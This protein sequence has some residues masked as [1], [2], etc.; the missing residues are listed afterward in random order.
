MP[1]QP[2]SAGDEDSS[3]Q[4]CLPAATT[5]P[6][7]AL[8]IVRSAPVDAPMIVDLDHTLHLSNSTEDFID[9]ARPRTV[10]VVL[11]KVAA[12]AAPWRR[13]ADPF[14]SRE[15][16][17]VGLITWLMPW[18]LLRW[19]HHLRG[20]QS[21]NEPLLDALGDRPVIVA[22]N[23]Y[24]VSAGRRV[25][26]RL[27]GA[28]VIARSLR[29]RRIRVDDKLERVTELIG[30]EELARSTVV[31]DSIDDQRLLDAA[32]N[33]VLTVWPGA[34]FRPALSDAYVPLQYTAAK[35]GTHFLLWAILLDD[36]ALA[37]IFA[38]AAPAAPVRAVAGVFLLT[39]AV[40]FVYDVGYHENDHLGRA[41]EPP[42]TTRARAAEL[43]GTVGALP[44]SM[45][46]L[47]AAGAAAF[48]THEDDLG[49]WVDRAGS[50]LATLAALLCCLAGLRAVFALFNRVGPA[51]RRYLHPILQAA[52]YGPYA[53]LLALAPVA[54]AALAAQVALRSVPYALYRRRGPSRP[55]PSGPWALIRLAVFLTALPLVWPDTTS[56]R[57]LTAAITAWFMIRARRDAVLVI[58]AARRKLA[59]AAS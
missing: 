31:T 52:R 13:A 3:A 28:T 56:E 49:I 58:L 7:D 33:G 36:V 10:A 14:A 27:P 24:H 55:F 44:A 47:T 54:W 26:S 42:P 53:V 12:L 6:E 39:L 20:D 21:W 8:A 25:A 48:V 43:K 1:R 4:A 51:Y 29:H 50:P 22:T 32:A 59:T 45:W 46:T 2:F 37:V 40:R 38:L 41:N 18:T 34:E 35:Q 11:L 9:S 57:W 15:R 5:S 19:R 30:G 16:W 23:G 17:R